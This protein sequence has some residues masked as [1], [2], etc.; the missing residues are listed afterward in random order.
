MGESV[1]SLLTTLPYP[2]G[3]QHIP[4]PPFPDFHQSSPHSPHGSLIPCPRSCQ[5]TLSMRSSPLQVSRA[6]NSSRDLCLIFTSGLGAVDSAGCKG[7]RAGDAGVVVEA[8]RER[9]G[10]AV[11]HHTTST[12]LRSQS[13]ITDSCLSDPNSQQYKINAFLLCLSD[14]PG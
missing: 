5:G 8:L 1:F 13:F 4:A 12:K 11:P 7:E 10:K 14:T 9:S 6:C 3:R 2:P